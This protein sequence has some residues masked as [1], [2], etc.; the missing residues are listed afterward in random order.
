MNP[1]SEELKEWER[2]FDAA[3]RRS[4]R[5]RMEYSFIHTY[6]PVMDDV[7]Y[8]SFDTMDD[9]R[10]WCRENLPAYLGYW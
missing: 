6:K 4:L 3:S 2:E 5:Q 1:T 7:P 8:R 9:Y 10:R